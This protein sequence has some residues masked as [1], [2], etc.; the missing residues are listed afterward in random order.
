MYYP[1][2]FV[3]TS[4][5]RFKTPLLSL[6]SLCQDESEVSGKVLTSVKYSFCVYSLVLNRSGA[7]SLT[8]KATLGLSKEAAHCDFLSQ[9]KNT[10]TALHLKGR[11]EITF[12]CK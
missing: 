7:A 4:Y 1:S 5:F 9:E 10:V 12:W 8:P 11:A 6:I 2:W 3:E